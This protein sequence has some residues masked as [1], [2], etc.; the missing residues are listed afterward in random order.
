MAGRYGVGCGLGRG[1]LLCVVVVRVVVASLGGGAFLCTALDAVKGVIGVADA[2]GILA[3]VGALVPRATGLFAR[4]VLARIGGAVSDDGKAYDVVARVAVIA[5]LRAPEINPNGRP[6]DVGRINK[7]F[8][9]ILY[10]SLVIRAR[11]GVTLRVAG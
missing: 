8:G 4:L 1:L 5:E 10:P 7:L 6:A 9:H 3:R 11:A 2:L